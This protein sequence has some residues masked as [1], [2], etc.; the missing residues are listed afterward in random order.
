[1]RKKASSAAV[2]LRKKRRVGLQKGRAI[3][4]AIRGK[5]VLEFTYNGRRR[6]AEPQTYGISTAGKEVLRAYQRSGGS[7]AGQ[8]RMAKLFDVAK[9]SQLK[10]TDAKF[11][12]ALPAH[13]PEDSAMV[14]IFATLPKDG[15]ASRER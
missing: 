8:I 10:K 11:G 4:S 1:M 15:R 7:R 3:I 9:I 14:E 5:A 13:N 6:I 2:K 12:G